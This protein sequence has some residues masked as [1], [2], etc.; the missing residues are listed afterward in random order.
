MMEPSFG[1]EAAAS[2]EQVVGAYTQRYP[3]RHD[4][5][6]PGGYFL[7]APLVGVLQEAAVD[8]SAS[9][10]FPLPYYHRERAFWMLRRISFCY[11]RPLRHDDQLMVTTWV[12]RV[13]K[14]S[15]T[16]E[17]RM[18][19]ASGEPIARVR[20]FWVYVDVTT[21]RSKDIP[22][23]LR[24]GFAPTDEPLEQVLD[25]PG[26]SLDPA[27]PTIERT[28]DA[29]WSDVDWSG[30]V[31]CCS[32][33]RW[34]EDLLTDMFVRAGERPGVTGLT[35]FD[36]QFLA[37]TKAGDRLSLRAQAGAAWKA[38]LATDQGQV[39]ALATLWPMQVDRRLTT[40]APVTAERLAQIRA[41]T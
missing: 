10:G 20:T 38:E 33:V 25:V 24:A 11:R 6:G 41:A 12:S 30:H 39:V 31:K 40:F 23:D 34:L 15:P 3:L 37:A 26:G 4:E 22:D 5:L 19:T 18:Q 29:S 8:G 14:T 17:Y 13:G 21:G 1:A 32:Y 35:S 7:P 16:R 36:L 2:P 27:A 28:C 9:R